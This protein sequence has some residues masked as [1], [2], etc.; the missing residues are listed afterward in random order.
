MLGLPGK[1]V[2]V[3]G[4]ATGL[5][6]ASAHRLAREG[7]LVV[8]GDLNLAGAERT[9]KAV[10]EAGGQAVAAGFDISDDDSVKDLVAFTAD[11]YGGLD[12][13][14]INAGD[15]GAVGQDTDVV[16]IDLA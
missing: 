16:D 1:V 2:L 5:G 14:H 4:A 6:A 12:A 3:A 8:V 7:A 13:V 9:A 15:M 10:T 11:T